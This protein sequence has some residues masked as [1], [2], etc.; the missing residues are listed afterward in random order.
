MDRIS[1]IIHNDFVLLKSIIFFFHL[2]FI[3][4]KA[5]WDIDNDS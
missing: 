3:T 2:G 4:G 1:Q 5:G